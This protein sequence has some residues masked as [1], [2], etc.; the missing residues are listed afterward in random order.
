MRRLTL[1]LLLGVLF[2]VANGAMA[3]AAPKGGN[4][5]IQGTYT[6]RDQGYSVTVGYICPGGYTSIYGADLL[7]D[8][9]ATVT[10]PGTARL[11]VMRHDPWKLDA[12]LYALYGMHLSPKAFEVLANDAATIAC[13]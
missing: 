9:A 11:T 13:T 4:A 2:A 5:A 3:G 7:A 12:S 8:Y 10:K 1:I 6:Y